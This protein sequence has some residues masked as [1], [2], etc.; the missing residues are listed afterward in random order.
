MKAQINYT[1]AT[2][3]HS[4]VRLEFSVPGS[5][6]W[7][8]FQTIATGAT[9][10]KLTLSV[11]AVFEVR[12]ISINGAE[13]SLPSAPITISYADGEAAL[14]P[15]VALDPPSNVGVVYTLN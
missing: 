10:A 14:S 5:G 11:G 15:P 8:V 7:S 12:L 9:F 1:A 4:Q 13:E 6:T 2:Q 3:A